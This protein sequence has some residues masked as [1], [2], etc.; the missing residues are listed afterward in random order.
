MSAKPARSRARKAVSGTK[1]A[2][3]KRGKSSSKKRK[4]TCILVLGMHQ[5]GAGALTRVL[6]FLGA[7]LPRHLAGAG[8]GAEWEHWEPERLC[9]YHERFLNDLQSSW[10][11]W[12]PLDLARLPAGSRD[13]VRADIAQIIEDDYGASPLFV[14]NE[15]R[16][17]RFAAFFIDALERAGIEVV[18]I[19]IA[20][21]PLEGS[22]SPKK[23]GQVWPDGLAD[24]NAALSW[25]SHVLEAEYATRQHTRAVITYDHL[26]TDWR[27]ALGEVAK[28][29]NLDFSQSLDEAAPLID[30]FVKQN[31]HR[32]APKVSDLALNPAV[33]GWAS[34]AFDRMA[35]LTANPAGLTA[36]SDLDRIRGEFLGSAPILDNLFAAAAAAVEVA[37][38]RAS[39]NLPE[40]ADRANQ[41]VRKAEV[42]KRDDGSSSMRATPGVETDDSRVLDQL[43]D[44]R[45][46]KPGGS[47]ETELR[48]IRLDLSELNNTIE[49]ISA[50]LDVAY[51][52]A[53]PRVFRKQELARVAKEVAGQQREITG[54]RSELAFA[55]AALAAFEGSRSWR[56]TAPLR[57]ITRSVSRI[58]QTPGELV[59]TRVRPVY[60]AWRN[61]SARHG[62]RDIIRRSW[63][64]LSNEGLSGLFVTVNR[65][66]KI[67]GTPREDGAPHPIRASSGHGPGLQEL[68]DERSNFIAS[69][70]DRLPPGRPDDASV[71]IMSDTEL[72]Q[73]IRYRIKN[74]IE[75]LGE[76][77][78]RAAFG[79]PGDVYKSISELQFYRTLLFYRMPMNDLFMI[80][81]DEARRLGMSIGYDLDDP[82]FDRGAL[83]GN[84]NLRVIE[85][86]YRIGQLRD[87]MRFRQAMEAC[88][89][90]TA[91]TPYLGGLMEKATGNSNVFLW[92]NVA[93]RKAIE[94]GKAT[95]ELAPPKSRQGT[96]I[97]YFSGSLAHEADFDEALPAL[98]AIMEARPDINLLVVG[99]L[100]ER[101]A[102]AKFSHR[103]RREGFSDYER[104]LELIATCDFIIIPLVDD[105]FNRCKSVVR[106][107]DAALV[108]V[109]VVASAVGDYETLLEHRKTAY[110]VRDR[111]WHDALVEAITDAERRNAVAANAKKLV[112]DRYSTTTY[113]PEIGAPFNADVLGQG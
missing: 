72:S 14:L 76:L 101:D 65:A 58:V 104:Y 102:F 32:H 83:G 3:A 59:R 5:S 41:A 79:D 77:G 10:S 107:I 92:R 96:L 52:P 20:R 44:E 21:N 90:L 85:P 71:F 19:V 45:A 23:Y 82:T 98:A 75:N 15:P 47:D 109:P 54:L 97:G 67:H 7:A 17:C 2:S 38:G 112:L 84:S 113:R 8:E 108:N 106:F 61:L 87:T 69:L 60:Q 37:G 43:V 6:N 100:G 40:V 53:S 35:E 22:A 111:N 33:R 36:R 110:L 26:L 29:A 94:A 99:H 70:G 25:L 80:Y 48:A 81:H 24:A 63:K 86:H 28:Q 46:R 39:R 49:Q 64:L 91:S 56:L 16:I 57:G 88:D 89:F 103:I 18:P 27:G 55:Q 30:E 31:P 42:A 105:I 13:Q 95:L 78:V 93:D 62:K 51:D 11:D 1:A 68:L 9:R 34:E 73:C 4:R 66:A 74:K 12:R 50:E